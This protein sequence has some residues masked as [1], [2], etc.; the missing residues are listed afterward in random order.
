MKC[1]SR[2]TT[3]PGTPTVWLEVIG[4]NMRRRAPF[5]TTKVHNCASHSPVAPG[6]N[7]EFFANRFFFVFIRDRLSAT[8]VDD[9]PLPTVTVYTPNVCA[10]TLPEEIFCNSGVY[11]RR[12]HIRSFEDLEPTTG[13]GSPFVLRARL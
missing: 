8:P 9:D 11:G 7:R 2:T 5:S 12:A 6:R 3:S 1:S 10:S 4:S 13:K